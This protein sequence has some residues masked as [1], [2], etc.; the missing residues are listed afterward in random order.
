MRRS[1]FQDR[2][3]AY[4]Y[5]HATTKN[6]TSDM[7]QIRIVE[8]IDAPPEAV[9]ALISDI[10]RGPEWVTVMEEVVHVSDEQ[11]TQ[12]TV[13][14]EISKIGPSRS[15]TE[16]RITRFD[17]P[18]VQIHECKEPTLQATLTMQVEPDGTGSRFIHQTDFEMLPVFRPLGWLAESLVGK[19][20]M[21]R[22]MTQ[23]VANAKRLLE[24]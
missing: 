22:E 10:R 23:T 8:H 24:T 7:P 6:I 4:L 19:R 1:Y 17:P 13:Y 2:E 16:W 12:G 15:E 21:Q 9:W 20:L 18:R 5:R 3:I 14:R 11:T